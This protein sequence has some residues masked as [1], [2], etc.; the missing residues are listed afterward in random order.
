MEKIRRK[1]YL[2]D[3]WNQDINFGQVKSE[4]SIQCLKT[5]GRQ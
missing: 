4:M 1:E 3:G 2:V 5:L